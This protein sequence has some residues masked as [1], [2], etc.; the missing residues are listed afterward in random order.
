MSS[1]VEIA[2][3]RD[4]AP[5]AAAWRAVVA[6]ARAADL[7]GVPAPV[8][9]EVLAG[10]RGDAHAGG[11]MPQ[12][13]AATGAEGEVTAVAGVRPASPGPARTAADLQ[14]YVHPAARRRGTG[15]LMLA[16]VAAAA[17]EGGWSALRAAAPA[18]TPADVF[19]LRHGF[20][21]ERVVH[22]LLLPLAEVHR[23]WL[24][25]LVYADHPGYRLTTWYAPAIPAPGPPA[26]PRTGGAAAAAEDPE[27]LAAAVPGFAFGTGSGVP[28]PG[29]GRL[30]T[31]AALHTGTGAVA[32]YTEVLIPPAPAPR[33]Q[34]CHLAVVPAH[35]RRGLARWITAELLRRLHAEHPQIGE[36][37]TAAADGDGAVLA[38]GEQLGFRPYR[39]TH[40]Y[41]LH[42]PG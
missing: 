32:G 9:E 21:R 8:R 41:R 2:V 6:A 25:E 3:V 5:A 34:H 24:A 40:D 15:T 1:P 42:L 19:C 7:P 37:E 22:H 14:L 29:S 12:A 27:G 35:R 36:V 33:A 38:L 31:V 13:W 30:L 26:L 28:E 39:R 18:C 16:A 4:A 17:R 20:V 11:A 10:L 23:A